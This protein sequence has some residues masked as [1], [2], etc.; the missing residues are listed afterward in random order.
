[1]FDNEEPLYY[2]TEENL[3]AQCF[4]MGDIMTGCRYRGLVHI[5]RLE[6]NENILINED[7]I[8]KTDIEAREF[9]ED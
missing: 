6:N 3:I 2:I 7:Y 4:Y 9:L 1:M 5:K 8:F